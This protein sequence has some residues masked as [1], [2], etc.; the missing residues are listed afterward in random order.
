MK[1]G[2]YVTLKAFFALKIFKFLSWRIGHVEKRLDYKDNINFKIYDVTT[3]VINNC[4]THN[5][6]YLTK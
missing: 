4:N 6:Q 1:T 3:W 2:F 5:A